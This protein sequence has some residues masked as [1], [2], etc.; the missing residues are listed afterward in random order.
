MG[1][2]PFARFRRAMRATEPE[3]SGFIER[4]G[5]R[6]YY[7]AY[8]SGPGTI[9]VLP[10]WSVLDSSHGR[11]QL[12]DLSRH[13]RVVTFDGRGNG[14][15]DRPVGRAAYA[16]EEFVQDALAVLDA[17]GTDRAVVVA[18]SLA[19]H[20][21]LRLAAEHPDRVLGA[22]ASGTNLPLG[23]PDPH[24]DMGPF[25]DPEYWRTHYEAFLRFFFSH[26]WSEPHSE[27]LIESCV[28]TGLQTTGDTLIDTVGTNRMSQ[29]EAIELIHRTRC[30]WLVIH[31]D[32]DKVQPHARAERLAQETRGRLVTLAGAG[33]C[34]G[35]RDPVRF[36]LL[37]R[38]FADEVLGRP[39]LRR[40]WRR[41][42]SRPRTVLMVP[43]DGPGTL[44]RDLAIVSALRRRRPE[45]RIEWLVDA[46]AQ[47]ALAERGEVIHAASAELPSR[48]VPVTDGFSA[49]RLREEV[50]FVTFTVLHDLVAD[51]PVDLVVADRAW[52]VDHHLHENPELKSFAYAWVTDA[53][54]W[55]PEP[56]ADDRGRDLVADANA[57]MIDQVERRPWVRDAAIYLG[58]PG[59]LSDLRLGPGL[60]SAREWASGRFAFVGQLS[61]GLAGDDAVDRVTERLVKLI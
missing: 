36:N 12:A 33:H 48:P 52:G 28:A 17:T 42:A 45:L 13:Y 44:T 6:V 21:M 5:V 16:G 10:T 53:I 3:D 8:G 25:A 32:E 1:A 41:A 39:G 37:V 38:E 15:S 34:S 31:G 14:K 59:G 49:W 4:D 24:F 26:V 7:E 58:D 27:N 61:N 18:C 60:P 57:G 51:D 9:L 40:T 11:F 43:G 54:G 47:A 50:D 46:S 23:A 35:N 20:W 2:G 30:P 19:T 56:G 22:V 55:L 29:G